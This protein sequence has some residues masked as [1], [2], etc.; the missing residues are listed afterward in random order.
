MKCCLIQESLASRFLLKP[1]PKKPTTRRAKGFLLI[2]KNY[3]KEVGIYHQSHIYYSKRIRLFRNRVRRLQLK[4][5]A[6]YDFFRI[7]LTPL[8]FYVENSLESVCLPDKNLNI[9]V[10]SSP[11]VYK[12]DLIF[13][14]SGRIK[15]PHQPFYRHYRITVS[16]N[17]VHHIKP[18]DSISHSTDTA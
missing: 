9:L 3:L 11:K 8:M 7:S 2:C 13:R 4:I 1:T 6:V 5:R 16:K 10:D 12:I 18:I 15:T 17:M 14:I